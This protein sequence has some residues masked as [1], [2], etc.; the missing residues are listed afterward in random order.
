MSCLYGKSFAVKR[1]KFIG[2]QK[3]LAGSYLPILSCL[4]CTEQ[5]LSSVS[6]S[7]SWAV[8]SMS[9]VSSQPVTAGRTHSQ[10]SRHL[11]L[12]L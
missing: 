4:E 6:Q 7:V 9:S 10:V 1:V 11:Q 5:W 8:D 2:L 3:M 12:D